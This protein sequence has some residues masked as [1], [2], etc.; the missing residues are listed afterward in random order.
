MRSA[1]VL[2][3][4]LCF[5]LVPRFGAYGAAAATSTALVVETILLLRRHAAPA[6]LFGPALAQPRLASLRGLFF[7]PHDLIQK[8]VPTFWDHAAV[9]PPSIDRFA[10][11][12]WLASSPHR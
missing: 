9:H 10:P 5:A 2:N 7:L 4:V 11:V 12:I 8:P 3:V 1:F 6:R